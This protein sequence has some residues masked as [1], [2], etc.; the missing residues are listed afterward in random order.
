MDKSELY[1]LVGL[2]VGERRKALNLTQEGVAARI[3]VSRPSLANMERGKQVIG[4]HLVY[5]L[6]SVLDLDTIT[7]LV[8]VASDSLAK[9]TNGNRIGSDINTNDGEALSTRKIEAVN[10][11]R[12]Q[13]LSR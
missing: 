10:R 7:Q 11:A 4:L 13:I 6:M 2:R 8:P 1:A 3:G 5:D 9:T 12:M